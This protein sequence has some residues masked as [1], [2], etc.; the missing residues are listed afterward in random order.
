M[1]M[2]RIPDS[3]LKRCNIRNMI[4]ENSLGM[5]I[6]SRDQVEWLMGF[7]AYIH[8]RAMYNIPKGDPCS[9]MKRF[10]RND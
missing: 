4:E 7:E 6:N 3:G 10:K 9:E 2:Y 8:R 5:V 1:Y